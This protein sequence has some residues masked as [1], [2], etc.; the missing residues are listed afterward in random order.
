MRRKGL[1][2]LDDIYIGRYTID[3]GYRL[4][5]TMLNKRDK[6]DLPTALFVSN[7]ILVPGVLRALHDQHIAVPD[8]MSIVAFNDNGLSQ[9]Y[10][11]AITTTKVY[12]EFMGEEA[13]NLMMERL[14]KYT[15]HMP[16]KSPCRQN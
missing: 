11:P 6:Q 13:V 12:S 10:F 16:R 14:D 2:Q 3:D 9:Y 5:N 1:F 7:D 4:A 8:E 15:E